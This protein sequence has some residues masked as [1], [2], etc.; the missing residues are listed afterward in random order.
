MLI[1]QALLVR[2]RDVIAFVGGGGKSTAMFCLADELVAQGKHVVTTT[3]TRLYAAQ[4]QR[5]AV[6]LRYD[7]TPDFVSHVGEALGVHSHVIIVGDQVEEDKVAGVPPTLVDVLTALE[8]LDAVLVEADGAR[9]RPLKGPAVHEPVVPAVTTIFIPMVGVTAVGA[10]LDEEHVHRPELVARITGSQI[11]QVVTP[12]TVARLLSHAQGGLKGKPAAARAV[13]LINQVDDETRLAT[14]HEAARL[15]LGYRE[16]DSVA[17]G[18]VQDSQNPIREVYRRV[19]AIV[20]AAGAGTRM[21]NRVKQLLPWRGGTLIENAVQI[22]TGANVNSTVVVLGARAEEI[23]AIVGRQPVRVVI[24]PD[25][26]EGHST[27]IRAGLRALSPEFDAAIF[28]NADQPRLAPPILNAIIQR[29]RETGALIVAPRYGGKRGSPVLF[30]R[31]Y[32]AELSGL[33][34]E[35]GGREVL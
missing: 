13:V 35:E 24:N 33:S 2:P 5:D 1:S 15:L 22:A 14:A 6:L 7:L 9:R 27:S 28:M 18:A 19:A 4:T 10:P 30:D 25:W 29:Y 32:F 3:T 31:A 23:R 12:L 21:G 20:L 34:G 26:E 11:G 8:G 16:I 17:I